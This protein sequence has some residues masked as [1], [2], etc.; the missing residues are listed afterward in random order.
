[1]SIDNFVPD[2]NY[3][4]QYLTEYTKSRYPNTVFDDEI[5][6]DDTVRE[7]YNEVNSKYVEWE[8]NEEE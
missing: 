2:I 4:R 1:M 3:M 6:D 7:M 8:Y 5:L